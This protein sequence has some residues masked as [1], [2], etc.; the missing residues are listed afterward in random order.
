MYEYFESYKL[1]RLCCSQLVYLLTCFKVCLIFAYISFRKSEV[2][3]NE[4][5]TLEKHAYLIYVT[6]KVQ[7]R[8]WHIISKIVMIRQAGCPQWSWILKVVT[9]K[10]FYVCLRKIFSLWKRFCKSFRFRFL[11]DVQA[12]TWKIKIVLKEIGKHLP[13]Q[14]VLKRHCY[15]TRTYKVC[16]TGCTTNF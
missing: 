8:F 12:F 13:H 14:T 6:S 2:T 7:R 3:G 11:I 16:S 4:V 10:R 5:E 15:Y 1:H 9:V